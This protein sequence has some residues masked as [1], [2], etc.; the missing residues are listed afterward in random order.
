M[1]Y[2]ESRYVFETDAGGLRI[3][4]TRVSLDSVVIYHQMGKTPEQIVE[5][6]STVPLSHAYGAIAYYLENKALIDEY[7]AE[8]DRLVASIP[9][10]SESAPELYAKLVAAREL[11]KSKTA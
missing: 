1:G 4:G 10:L 11:L 3:T 2:P 7:I 6:F 8:G 5:A 9:P